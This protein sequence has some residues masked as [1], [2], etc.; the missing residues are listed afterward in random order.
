MPIA[1]LKATE[2][3]YTEID[4]SK[5]VVDLC[6]NTDNEYAKPPIC[7]EISQRGEKYRFGTFGNFSVIGGKSKAKKGFI[8]SSILASAIYG[9]NILNF[10]THFNDKEIVLFDTEQGDYDLFI[11]SKRIVRLNQLEFHPKKLKVFALRQLNTEDRVVFIENYIE[12]NKNIG[13]IIIDGIR[14]LLIDINSTDQSTELTTK[15]MQWTK[16]YNIHATVVLHENPGSDKLRGHIGT[17]IMNKAETVISVEM[18]AENNN[19]SLVKPRYTR[20]AKPFD[21]F[22]FEINEFGLPELSN[23]QPEF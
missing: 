23:Y 16:V 19:V 3:N 1:R 21:E 6:I 10:K 9:N 7:I 20:G 22:S 2:T 17:E 14:D 13:L 8:V 15:L 12:K 4:Y 5:L 11:A 18:V